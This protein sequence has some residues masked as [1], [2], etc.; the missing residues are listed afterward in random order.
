[1]LP[2]VTD[3]SVLFCSRATD[4]LWEIRLYHIILLLFWQ[5][6][7]SKKVRICSPL[8]QIFSLFQEKKAFPEGICLQDTNRKLQNLSTLHKWRKIF[9]AYQ[10]PLRYMFLDLIQSLNCFKFLI[11]KYQN[12][13]SHTVVY[14]FTVDKVVFLCNSTRSV[15]SCFRWCFFFFFFYVVYNL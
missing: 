4:T 13:G 3:D 6:F 10:G 11:W 2:T 9:Q 5:W 8:E 14:N 12:F 1:M 7:Y 15:R